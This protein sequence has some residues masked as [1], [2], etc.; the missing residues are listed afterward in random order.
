MTGAHP[1]PTIALAPLGHLVIG[2]RQ[3]TEVGRTPAG[4]RIV[5]EVATCRWES[6]RV[7]AREHGQMSHDWLVEHADGSV[8]IDARLLLVTDDG[9]HIGITYRGRADRQPRLGG[10]IF[11]TPV[12]ETGDPRYAWLNGVQ[13]VARGIRDGQV[14]R[15]DLY[16]LESAPGAP[17]QVDAEASDGGNQ[18]DR[19]S[20]PGTS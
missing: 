16:A 9:A 12:F 17:G 6:E 20:R 8:G 11:T 14:L 15:Y 5:G 10:V 19:P 13:A 2:I 18:P 1:P 4:L 3:H 7:S